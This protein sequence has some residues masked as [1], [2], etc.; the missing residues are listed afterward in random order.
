MQQ[1]AC[2]IPLFH[3]QTYRFARPEVEGLEVSHGGPCVIYDELAL[4]DDSASKKSGEGG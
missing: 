2:L 3:P 4:R 1:D